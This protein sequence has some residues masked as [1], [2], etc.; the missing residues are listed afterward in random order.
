M[1]LEISTIQKIA[2]SGIDGI[3]PFSIYLEDFGPGQGKIT[4]TSFDL[5]LSRYWSHMGQ[6][7]TI[8]SFFLKASDGYL[9][10]KLMQGEEMSEVAI[11]LV[12]EKTIAEII[13]LRRQGSITRDNARE[14]YD[15]AQRMGSDVRDE[16]DLLHAVFGDDWYYS[17]PMRETHKCLQVIDAIKHT[18]AALAKLAQERNP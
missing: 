15:D 5:A 3:D 6:Q 16:A 12:Q 13:A 4:I 9:L 18:K 8:S 7:H 10:S 1:R 17:L 14:L 11:D 2:V